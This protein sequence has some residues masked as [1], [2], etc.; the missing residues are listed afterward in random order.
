MH[1][2]SFLECLTHPLPPDILLLLSQRQGFVGMPTMFP[3]H[4]QR[5]LRLTQLATECGFRNIFLHLP[6]L[7]SAATSKPTIHSKIIAVIL[8]ASSLIYCLP[9]GFYHD[10]S[11]QEAVLG[12]IV[13][14]FNPISTTVAQCLADPISIIHIH[15]EGLAISGSPVKGVVGIMS[16]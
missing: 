1:I 4:L 15:L 8:S 13:I 9:Q 2:Y 12:P 11:L 6:R 7:P 5:P 14:T 16:E 10:L 3:S